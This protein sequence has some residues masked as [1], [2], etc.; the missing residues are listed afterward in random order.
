MNIIEQ[1]LPDLMIR[2]R[3]GKLNAS[4]GLFL[5]LKKPEK[6]HVHVHVHIVHLHAARTY[7]C[8]FKKNIVYC[9]GGEG[10]RVTYI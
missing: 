2:V 4:L 10:M 6:L 7:M 8:Q 3:N 1:S 9:G 5:F